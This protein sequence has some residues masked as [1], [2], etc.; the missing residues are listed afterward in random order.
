M[1]SQGSFSLG[2][3][4]PA[5]LPGWVPYALRGWPTRHRMQSAARVLQSHIRPIL[6]SQE[7][8]PKRGEHRGGLNYYREAHSTTGRS[9]ALPCSRDSTYESVWL[10]SLHRVGP[11]PP[12]SQAAPHLSRPGPEQRNKA[13][14][15]RRAPASPRGGAPPSLTSRLPPAQASL[16][17][18]VTLLGHWQL[19]W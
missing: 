19:P 4:Y 5:P 13:L 9:R 18:D 15:N 2:L 16:R 3:E 8:L 7:V 1:G 17:H 10:G 14:G 12:T 6:G 11:R